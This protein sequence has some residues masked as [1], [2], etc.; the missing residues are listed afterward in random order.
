MADGTSHDHNFKN[1]VVDYPRQSLEFF[2]P[3]QAPGAEDDIRVVPVRQEQLKDRLGDAFRALDAPLLVEWAD[4]RHE[5]VA[6]V[7][8]EET[9]PRRFSPYRLGRYC[10]GLAELLETDRVVPVVVFLRSGAAPASV[11]LGAKG[12]TFMAFH[13]VACHLADLPAERW[14]DSRNLVARVNLPNMRCEPGRRV[15]VYAHA[16]R[17]LLDLEPDPAKQGK[18]IDFIDI[19]ADLTGNERRRYEQQYPE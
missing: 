6:F 15:E 7:L 19:Y 12:E 8:E 3:G 9:D 17:G 10:L 11:A 1:L 13:Y 16:V 14:L 18:Y 5:A 2:A 4:D